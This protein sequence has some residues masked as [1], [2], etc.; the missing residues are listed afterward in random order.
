MT[1]IAV[2]HG[3][4]ELFRAVAAYF[5]QDLIEN[6][7]AIFRLK[8]GSH[9]MG[10]IEWAENLLSQPISNGIKPAVSV[11]PF[12]QKSIIQVKNDGLDASQLNAAQGGPRFLANQPLTKRQSLLIGDILFKEGLMITQHH[13]AFAEVVDPNPRPL[14]QPLSY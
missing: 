12:G 4:H 8:K 3:R 9:A 7:V 5:N 13:D 2:N 1:A 11:V 10:C 14:S 6:A